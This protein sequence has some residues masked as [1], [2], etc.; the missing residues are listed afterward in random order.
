MR[1]GIRAAD[2]LVEPQQ[3]HHLRAGAPATRFVF[4]HGAREL[5][6][7][8]LAA[9]SHA[10]MPASLLDSQ[11]QT[12]EAPGADEGAIE[13]DIA[14]PAEGLVGEALRRLENAPA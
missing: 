5:L 8:R 3:D 10:Y 7:D 14:Q 2:R 4:L 12:L 13:L 1:P 6:A 9:R 11:L